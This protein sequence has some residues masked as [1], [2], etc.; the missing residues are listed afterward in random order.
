MTPPATKAALLPP[1]SVAV[2]A[3]KAFSA[4][5]AENVVELMVTVG[6]GGEGGGGDGGGDGGGGDG[7]GDAMATCR[8]SRGWV[9]TTVTLSNA[10]N[11]S[12]ELKIGSDTVAMTSSTCVSSMTVI[13]D[14][15]STLAETMVSSMSLGATP[16]VAARAVLYASAS[17]SEMEPEIVTVW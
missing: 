5:S 10:P 16:S 3:D 8:I 7:G 11:E 2:L 6:G 9:R 17:N 12:G 13:W 14:W 4:L 1:P 15:T